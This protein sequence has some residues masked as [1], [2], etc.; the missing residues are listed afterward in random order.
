MHERFSDRA[1][2]AMALA[3]REAAQL[4]HDYLAPA[5]LML[6]L[7]AE[8]ECVATETL[9][10]LE[11]DL[12]A[13]RDE[14]RA[15]MTEGGPAQSV[16][17]RAQ[18]KEL[19]EAIALAIA[20]ARK[21]NHRYVGTEHLV[22]GLLAQTENIPAAVLGRQG[23]SLDTVREKALGILRSS[24]DPSHDLAHSRHGDF[25]WVHQQELAKAF[26]SPMFWHTLI[27]AVDSANRMGAG[28]VQPQH[29]LLALLRDPANGLA[30]L[31]E[32]KGVTVD[33]L[34]QRFAEEAGG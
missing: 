33:W 32:T 17:R 20:E 16:G 29:L 28:E 1:R 13:V 14:V 26:R 8:G 4:G 19:K 21:F 5:H 31:L 34:R 2:H 9:R 23:V 25:E 6:G 24:L 7:I 22:L 18:T 11:V 10:V 30:D 12:A 15:Q 27:L 3:N